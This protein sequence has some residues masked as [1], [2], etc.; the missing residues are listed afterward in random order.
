MSLIPT[1]P[2][3]W[4][5]ILFALLPFLFAACSASPGEIKIGVLAPLSGQ[6]AETSGQPMVDAVQLAVD[7]VN[8]AGGLE[9]NGRRYEIV[10]VVEDDAA[11]PET[12]VS[13]ARKL[14]NQD[15]VMALI[16]PP[17]SSAAIPVA[18]VAEQAGV[19]M[20]SPT[21]TNTQ[22]TLDKTFVF[23]ATFVDVFQGAA[24]ARF[25]LDELGM[26][27]AAVLYDIANSYNR[28]LAET[29]Q[30]AF[31]AAAGG[32]IVAFESYTTDEN[33]DFS[34]QL[35]VIAA[36]DPDVLFL[37]NNT[38]DVLLQA[39]QARQMGINATILG[40]DSW[41]GERLMGQTPFDDAYFSGH[42]CRDDKIEAVRLFN[43]QFESAYGREPNGLIA[44]SY[45]SANLLLAAMQTQTELTPKSI[46]DG[47]YA[48]E[49]NGVTGEISFTDSGDPV[50]SVAIWRIKGDE[51]ACYQLINP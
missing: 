39:E 43:D 48:V 42:F 7:Q 26:N 18:D 1:F 36:A 3:R 27:R 16:G 6:Y 37:P 15:A 25:T 30:S 11:N 41:E 31:I 47:L 22:T 10:L 49:F 20:I 46:R 9:V 13:A 21:S 38:D 29:F 44:L 4:T 17:F 24:M 14:I 50:K 5:V 2:T 33:V 12:A 28:G 35:N 19:P 51:R 32:K 45:D 40:G 34:E 8:A 23:R